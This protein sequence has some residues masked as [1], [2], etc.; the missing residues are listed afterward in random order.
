MCVDLQG[1]NESRKMSKG[2][3]DLR[4]AN[5]ARVVALAVG[6]YTISLPSGLVLVLE[7]CYYVPSFTKNIIS[8]SRLHTKGFVFMFKNKSCSFYLNDMFYGEGTLVNGLYVLNTSTP[9]N[10][11]EAKK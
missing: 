3:M 7:N 11:I 9:V 5:G 2:E 6:T 1:L 8:V 4:V 10:C